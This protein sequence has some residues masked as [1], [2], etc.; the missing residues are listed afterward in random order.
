MVGVTSDSEARRAASCSAAMSWRA[1]SP[2][3][4]VP[5]PDSSFSAFSPF[6]GDTYL[7]LSSAS[8]SCSSSFRRDGEVLAAASRGDCLKG[9]SEVDWSGSQWVESKLFD[10][11]VTSS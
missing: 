6:V 3:L 4:E 11:L 10:L 7:E 8:F 2:T 1:A 5:G 9:T